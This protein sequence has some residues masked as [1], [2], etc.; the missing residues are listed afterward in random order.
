MVT[1][2]GFPLIMMVWDFE[3]VVI[4]I[5]AAVSSC[6]DGESLSLTIMVVLGFIEVLFGDLEVGEVFFLF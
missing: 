6:W 5:L 3:C 2:K 4:A 1:L